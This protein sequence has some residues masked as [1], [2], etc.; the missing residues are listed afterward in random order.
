MFLC[1]CHGKESP[2]NLFAVNICKTP[3]RW[4]DDEGEKKCERPSLK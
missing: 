4:E 1:G 2:E 3:P